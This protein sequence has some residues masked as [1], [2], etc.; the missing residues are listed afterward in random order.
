M[1][2]TDSSSSYLQQCSAV[3]SSAAGYMRLPVL[4]TSGIAAI[5]SSLLYFKQK[6]LIYPSNIPNLARTQVPRPP[7]FGITDFEE[8]MIPTPDGESL[9]AFYIRAPEKRKQNI[10][11][12]MFHGNAGNIGHRIPIAR[13]L[14]QSMDCSVFMLEY[15]GYG[16][17]SGSPDQLGLMIDGQT[18]FDYLRQRAETRDNDIVIFGQSL[19]GAVAVQLAAKNQNDKKLI[20]VVLEN[21]FLSMRKMIPYAIPPAKYLTWLCHQVW[22]TETFLPSISE[23]PILFLSG[24]RDEIVPTNANFR[25]LFVQTPTCFELQSI[26][27]P[28]TTSSLS[29]NLGMSTAD[30]SPAATGVPSRPPRF[31]GR[32]GANRGNPNTRPDQA[33]T[34]ATLIRP[35][36][37]TPAPN[38]ESPAPSNSNRGHGRRGGFGRGGR[39][40]GAQG[41]PMANG[42]IFGGQLTTPAMS[43]TGSLNGEAPVFVPGRPIVPRVQPPAPPPRLRR[44]SK[45]QAPDI[46][47]R[48]H[49]DITN[50]QYERSILV[51]CQDCHH[52]PVV[53]PVRKRELVIVHILVNLYAMRDHALLA[54]IWDLLYHAFAERRMLPDVA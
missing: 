31:R 13:M 37:V 26:T 35:G 45:S 1:S 17:S 9:S 12:L 29:I 20:G 49:E 21:T 52:I 51:P 30:P 53:K 18:A 23:L 33:S 19:G 40:G 2:S 39:R 46:A 4:I 22:P 47:T 38:P 27:T 54:A 48:T 24:L 32:R 10:T 28:Q 16:L 44:M 50:G 42:R 8:L 11:V 7:Q 5:L 34:A 43:S 25:I 6:A 36:S 14:M 41:Q 3:A 15:R